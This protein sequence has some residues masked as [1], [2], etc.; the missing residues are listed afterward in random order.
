MNVKDKTLSQGALC[1]NVYRERH[2]IFMW[3][4][5][6]IT[7]YLAMF[8]PY[9]KDAIYYNGIHYPMHTT[10]RDN[11]HRYRSCTSCL[12][13][14]KETRKPFQSLQKKCFEL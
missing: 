13:T 9:R 4:K 3:F 1:F 6:K 14:G 5:F 11:W 8:V 10:V 7:F 2:C 12:Y